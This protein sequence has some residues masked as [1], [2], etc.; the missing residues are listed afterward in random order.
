LS[1]LNLMRATAGIIGIALAAACG[2]EGE[3]GPHHDA[4]LGPYTA[5]GCGVYREGDTV[6]VV[7][8]FGQ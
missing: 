8:D 4:I 1:L 2:S 5:L 3:G 6:T 7:Q